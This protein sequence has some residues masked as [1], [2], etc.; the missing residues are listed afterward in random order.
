MRMVLKKIPSQHS[1][2]RLPLWS[3]AQT[4]G[5]SEEQLAINNY[6]ILDP[7][8]VGSILGS[9]AKVKLADHFEML[10]V[11]REGGAVDKALEA[12]V[13]TLPFVEFGEEKRRVWRDLAW[14]ARACGCYGLVDSEH[15]PGVKILR[16]CAN[17][18]EWRAKRTDAVDE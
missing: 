14:S 10:S 11:F 8:Y 12:V 16:V 9:E 13:L 7:E 18:A 3:I 4:L 5:W 1:T 15:W 17:P 6:G 2:E